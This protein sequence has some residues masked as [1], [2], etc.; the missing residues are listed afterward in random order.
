[1]AATGG[2]VEDLVMGE[3]V[4]RPGAIALDLAAGKVY[5]TESVSGKIRR[6][7][8]DGSTVED[9][10]DRQFLTSFGLAVDSHAGK[11]YWS[12]FASGTIERAN[13][14]GSRPEQLL[15]APN[16]VDAPMGLAIDVAAGHLYW[17]DQGSE[18]ILRATLDGWE[19]QEIVTAAAGLIEPQG[20]AVDPTNGFLYWTD[21]ST[22]KIQR[23]RLDGTGI[24]DV[25]DVSA[26]VPTIDAE[27]GEAAQCR[28]RALRARELFSRRVVKA[29]S[30]CLEKVSWVKAVKWRI[31][32]EGLAAGTCLSQFRL[33]GD[34]RQQAT[35]ARARLREEL[36]TACEPA[37]RANGS[38]ALPD[39]PGFA[40]C[41]G[42]RGD[43]TAWVGC[44]ESESRSDGWITVASRY[45]RT[46]EWLEGIRPFVAQVPPPAGDPEQVRDALVALD[47]F[48]AFVAGPPVHDR[49]LLPARWELGSGQTTAYLAQR[50]GAST[51]ASVPD[52]GAVQSG[53]PLRYVDNHDGTVTDL[54]T[55]LTWEKKCDGCGG[56]HDYGLALVWSGESEDETVW[57]WLDALNREA[58]LGFAGHSD[59][60][61]PSVKELVSIVDYERFNPAA[62]AAFDGAAC[63]LGCT[64]TTDPACSCTGMSFYWTSTTFADFPAHALTVRMNLGLVGDLPKTDRAFV[65]AVRG[66]K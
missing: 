22:A 47:A 17:A 9:L 13:L 19:V 37:A 20:L 63:G 65:R 25:I 10:L 57:D 12:D 61:I 23:A 26:S 28:R 66:G 21:A 15:G 1:V 49:P 59:W 24:E 41:S 3:D 11:L 50:K 29:L 53:G 8:L 60:R 34:S 44:V 7:N 14:D 31:A 6:S 58:A 27:T 40:S 32:D 45:P 36:R 52:D 35:D 48:H 54:A 18:K 5:W 62:P 2:E 39:G 64:D 56:L 42:R 55:G 30:T 33:L 38:A 51:A 4:N 43:L 46:L 16:G